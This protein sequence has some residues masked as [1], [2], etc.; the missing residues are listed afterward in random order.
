MQKSLSG[1][2][3]IVSG[4]KRRPEEQDG[5]QTELLSNLVYATSEA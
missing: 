3:G 2:Y 4:L 1:E 5:R